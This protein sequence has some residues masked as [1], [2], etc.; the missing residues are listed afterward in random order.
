MVPQLLL[1]IADSLLYVSA[2]LADGSRRIDRVIDYF[3][4]R[5]EIPGTMTRI[6]P[7][8]P[9]AGARAMSG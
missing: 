4:E 8:V 6:A 5:S 3:G 2:L 7:C 9:R 1:D